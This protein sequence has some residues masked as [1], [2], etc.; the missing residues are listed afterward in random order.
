M[1]ILRELQSAME[2]VEKE[3]EHKGYWYRIRDILTILDV[4]FAEDKTRIC[5]MNVQ[6][7]LNIMRKIAL[8][9]AKDFKAKTDSR[10]PISG[11]LKRN[12]FDINNLSD[13][14]TFFSKNLN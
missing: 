2:E 4:H 10:L 6:K 9:L 14:L 13:F 3:S 11:I 12:L 1:K 8:N 5:D 7:T